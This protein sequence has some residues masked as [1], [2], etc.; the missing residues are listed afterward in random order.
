MVNPNFKVSELIATGGMAS[1]YRGIQLSLDRPIAIKRL[2]PHLTNNID[3]V[4][5]FEKEAKSVAR[6]RHENIV[7]IIDFGRDEEGYYLALEF[8]EGKNLKEILKSEKKVPA[9]IG[10]IIAEQVAQG[11]RFAH[12][13]GLI[14]RDIKPANI[15]LSNS[16]GVKITDFGIAKFTGDVTVTATGSMIGSPAYMSPEHVRGTDLDSRADLFSLG[17]VLYE[18]LT[19]QKPFQGDNYQ[20]VITKILTEQPKPIMQLAPELSLGWAEIIHKCLE[21]DK[22]K[23]YQNCEDLLL[24][25]KKQFDFYQIQLAPKLI[26]EYLNNASLVASKLVENRIQ[27]HLDWGLHYFNQGEGQQEPAKK[28]FREVLRWDPH[29]QTALKYVAQLEKKDKP[30]RIR[31]VKERLKGRKISPWFLVP[32]GFVAAVFLGYLFGDYFDRVLRRDFAPVVEVP[33]KLAD[34]P[35]LTVQGEEESDLSSQVPQATPGSKPA[36]T[37]N[38]PLTAK[39]NRS[40]QSVTEESKSTPSNVIVIYNQEKEKKRAGEA[41]LL[42]PEELRA[43]LQ[44]GF[45]TVNAQPKATVEINGQVYG[46]VPP[47]LTFKAEEGKYRVHLRQEGYQTQSR[48]IYVQKGKTMTIEEILKEEQPSSSNS[49]PDEP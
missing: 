41:G 4:A 13:A 7:S 45:L 47:A 8:V 35:S 9:E 40:V 26:S 30:G 6:L 23:R 20:E 14:H 28:E 16:G 2:H 10:L 19:G 22:F 33:E 46:T 25:L 3:F 37:H 21:R 49:R 39:T 24:D 38:S 34:T 32:A 43:G 31:F 44:F 18:I 42:N 15:M 12:S 27:R 17:V 29:N 36:I 48:K 5:R 11:L 1:I